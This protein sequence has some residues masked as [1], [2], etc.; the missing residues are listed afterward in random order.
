MRQTALRLLLLATITFV[1]SCTKEL[2][3]PED[4]TTTQQ[5]LTSSRLTEE[6]L[7]SICKGLIIDE[8]VPSTVDTTSEIFHRLLSN[9]K[10]ELRS[11]DSELESESKHNIKQTL[12][13]LRDTPVHILV[14][15]NVG[16]GKYLTARRIKF[17]GGF[18]YNYIHA[19]FLDKLEEETDAFSQTFYLTPVPLIGLYTIKTKYGGQDDHYMI[20]GHYT[21]SPEDDFLYSE[22]NVPDDYM[23]LFD[24]I[25][26]NDR[27]SFYLEHFK[28]KSSDKSNK[29]LWHPALTCDN[30]SWAVFEKYRQSRRQEFTIVPVEEFELESIEYHN[31]YRA[32]LTQIPDFVITWTSINNTRVNQQMTTNFGQTASRTS[33]FSK[34]KSFS[35]S[36]KGDLNVGIPKVFEKTITIT[37][38][39]TQTATWGTS[40]TFQ[41]TRNYNFQV[42]VAPRCKVVAKAMVTRYQ[43]KMPYT[44]YLKGK[45]TGKIIRVSGIWEGVDYTDITC[46]YTEYDLKTN[47]PLATRSVLRKL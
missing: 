30:N 38:S 39:N 31:D 6:R 47:Q 3:Q 37:T 14:N 36:L 10:G 19:G 42:V 1:T 29:S 27:D 22:A 32:T 5:H 43:V 8:I 24:F 40:E 25:P 13:D 20:L 4:S 15:E 2:Q 16:K 11:S 44:A 23:K 41:D 46:N 7:D 17:W 28:W 35:F 45:K 21:T 33:S 26:S 9:R 12:F 18:Y 34:S